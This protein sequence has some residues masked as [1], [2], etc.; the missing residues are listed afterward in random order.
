MPVEDPQVVIILA[1]DTARVLHDM[2]SLQ[3]AG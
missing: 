1:E 2:C 3:E